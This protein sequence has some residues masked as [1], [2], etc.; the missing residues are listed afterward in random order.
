MGEDVVR[1]HC[2]VPAHNE[3]V[4]IGDCLDAI[5]SQGSPPDRVFVLADR[6][7][8]RTAEIAGERCAEVIPVVGGTKARA[9]NAALVPYLNLKRRRALS[10]EDAVLVVDADSF[11]DPDFL[12][13]AVRHLK[14]RPN[15]AAVGG[16]FRG[17]PEGSYWSFCQISEYCRY[18]RDTERLGGKALTLS[19]T[20]MVARVS[21][22]REILL[23]TGRVYTTDSLVEDLQLSCEL[24]RRGHDVLAPPDLTL[25]T[26]VMPGAGSLWRQRLR[27]RTGAVRTVA[28]LGWGRGTRE[29]TLRLAWGLVGIAA[30]AGYLAS[31]AYGAL[32]GALALYPLWLGV[33]LVFCVEQ[34]VT[35]YGRG[36]WRRALVGALLVYEMPY[37]L[38]L[39]ACHGW[40][41]VRAILP[42]KEVW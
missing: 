7:T 8:D 41:Y 29:L 22:L 33:T 36:G 27:W 16:T 20:A 2:F 3:E 21:A 26:E 42:E 10:D 1:V 31:L 4:V 6:C 15:V 34:A 35:V 32:T 12:E 18:A 5:N 38:F 30:T 23:Q 14:T 37:V 13:N 39:Q 19:G 40:A 25:T 11:L 28:H 17:R 9:L 24:M